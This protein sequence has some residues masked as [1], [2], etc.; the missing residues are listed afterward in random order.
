MQ[1]V[2]VKLGTKSRYKVPLREERERDCSMLPQVIDL[3]W[4]HQGKIHEK[5]NAIKLI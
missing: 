1:G 3:S 2:A 5:E 4:H